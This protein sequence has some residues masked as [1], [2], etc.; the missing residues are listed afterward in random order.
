MVPNGKHVGNE[1]GSGNAGAGKVN[2]LDS[3][4]T[5][6]PAPRNPHPVTQKNHEKAIIIFSVYQI[7][8]TP[9]Q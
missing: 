4:R 3:P 8:S 7:R 1:E 6:Q 5:P 2:N 9:K